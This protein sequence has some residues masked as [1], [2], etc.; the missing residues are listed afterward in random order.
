M[1]SRKEI[2]E[3]VRKFRKDKE[4]STYKMQKAG[5]S[6][7]LFAVIERGVTTDYQI[8]TLFDYLSKLGLEVD[9]I[10]SKESDGVITN[11]K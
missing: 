4:I 8:D 6:P 2:G 7:R 1:K 5:I 3:K 9:I 11:T 10:E